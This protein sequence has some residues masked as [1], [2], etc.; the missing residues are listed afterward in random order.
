MQVIEIEHEI[1]G[2]NLELPIIEMAKKEELP[3][4][5][6]FVENPTDD[7][8]IVALDSLKVEAAIYYCGRNFKE[9]D[10]YKKLAKTKREK[11]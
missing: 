6:P 2:L 4:L 7:C 11:R 5:C 3:Q 1:K 10:I 8:F 9:C